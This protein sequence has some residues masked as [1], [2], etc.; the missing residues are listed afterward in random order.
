MMQVGMVAIALHAG[1]IQGMDLHWQQYLRWV[2]LIVATPVI[3][4]SARPFFAGAWR[5]LKLGHLN[6]MDVPVSIALLLAYGASLWATVNNSGQVYFDSVSMFTFFLFGGGASWKCAYATQK[7]F[8]RLS[9]YRSFSR[10]RLILLKKIPSIM[11][12]SVQLNKEIYC[13][14]RR[15]K[16]FL[17]M[18]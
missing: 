5:A 7:C 4:F 17:V 13:E 2:S 3:L 16:Y 1:D 18:Q 14:Y 8:L 12:R 9:V 6:N 10:E 11:Y 15:V